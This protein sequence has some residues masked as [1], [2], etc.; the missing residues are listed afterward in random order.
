MEFVNQS[1][2][3]HTPQPNG[4]VERNHRHVLN[5]ARALLFQS[6]LLDGFWGERVLTAGYL[7]NLTPTPVF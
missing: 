3:I 7:I 4:H 2:M 5:V 6:N 1:T